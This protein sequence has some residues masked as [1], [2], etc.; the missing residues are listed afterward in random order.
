[1]CQVEFIVRIKNSHF[2]ESFFEGSNVN[3]TYESVDEISFE[4]DHS[5]EKHVFQPYFLIVVFILQH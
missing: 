4:C 2:F 1:M 5:N 3:L